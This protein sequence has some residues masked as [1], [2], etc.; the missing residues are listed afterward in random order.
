MLQ[1]REKCKRSGGLDRVVV[2]S[3]HW[4]SICLY[5]LTLGPDAE[6]QGQLTSQMQ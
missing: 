5:L 1:G 3:W 4:E 6:S 2:E